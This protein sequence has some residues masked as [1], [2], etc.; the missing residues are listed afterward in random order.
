M[1][2]LL[3]YL[4]ALF[5]LGFIKSYGQQTYTVT[6]F[7]SGNSGSADVIIPQAVNYINSTQN[8]AIVYMNANGFC[9]LS[10]PLNISLSNFHT[11]TGITIQ[12][13][14]NAT[15]PQGFTFSST[16]INSFGTL[17]GAGQID[18]PASYLLGL[19]IPGTITKSSNFF[20]RQCQI[21]STAGVDQPIIS[22]F[23]PTFSVT[24]LS[25]TGSPLSSINTSYTLTISE[26]QL[27]SNVGYGDV[28]ID[29]YRSNSN[30][31]ILDYLG[32]S[33][34]S[35]NDIIAADN[36]PTFNV[37]KTYNLNLPTGII[38]HSGDRVATTVN[39]GAG[40]GDNIYLGT[41]KA[42]YFTAGT[43][44]P[45]CVLH[46]LYLNYTSGVNCFTNPIITTLQ[47]AVN[48]A[49]TPPPNVIHEGVI[50]TTCTGEAMNLG[51]AV[52]STTLTPPCICSGG[53]QY[54]WDFGDGYTTTGASASHNY[55][56]GGTY[57]L[58]VIATSI[59]GTCTPETFTATVNVLS[60]CCSQ[61]AS[62]NISSPNQKL[63]PYCIGD[64]LNFLISASESCSFD[65][66]NISYQ[67][68]LSDGTTSSQSNF[69]HI[70]T[71]SG[72]YTVTL[73]VDNVNC[74]L[75]RSQN[76][77]AGIT[78]YTTTVQ[79]IDCV[80]FTPCADCIGS[81]APPAGDYIVSVWVREDQ[82][83]YI[84]SYSSGLTV[85][86]LDGSNNS[87]TTFAFTGSTAPVN[88]LI[89][90]W[91][92][93]E[94]R[95]TIPAGTATF[96]LS[97]NNN[98]T[99][100]ADAYFDDIRIHPFNSS[101]KSYVYD[102]ITL[103]LMAELDENNYAT[104]YEY[105]EDGALIRVKKETAKGIMTIKEARNNVKK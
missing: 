27:Y 98:S 35:I 103:R 32:S 94:Q 36:A 56:N 90:G 38:M 17:Q 66:N 29:F 80:G 49:Q 101:F 51:I 31:D 54:A 3:K 100:T 20:I 97:L 42:Y 7:N 43:S 104:F 89:D 67:W 52:N 1:H 60:D 23:N 33:F 22:D 46:N 24:A 2:K 50:L 71:A 30:G 59:T 13:S 5:L 41:S 40:N 96:Q 69:S 105:D 55:A 9:N 53:L 47:C 16:G 85:T 58:T 37:V 15:S 79:I 48:Q 11:S 45:C 84:D 95:F 87:I 102:P 63:G 77:G 93:I 14:P 72:T 10:S 82:S 70:F 8:S 64:G 99:P 18:D 92:K 21:K 34:L 19:Q 4:Y 12:N 61:T 76:S 62:I 28:N 73:T 75:S 39:S 68:T 81:F 6:D 74:S 88:K 26:T 86:C 44:T 25:T 91:Q 78:T 83:S 57:T 65:P